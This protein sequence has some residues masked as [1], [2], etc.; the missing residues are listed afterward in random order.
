[1]PHISD[2]CH[3]EDKSDKIVFA[4]HCQFKE[5]IIFLSK[6]L[7]TDQLKKSKIQK[8]SRLQHQQGKI[9]QCQANQSSRPSPPCRYLNWIV[10]R[11]QFI[12]QCNQNLGQYRPTTNHYFTK[13]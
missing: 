6:S 9:K 12:I 8:Y 5:N 4:L 10:S 3:R 13:F 2:L 11:Q 1:M 7:N